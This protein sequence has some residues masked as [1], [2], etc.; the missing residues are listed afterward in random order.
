MARIIIILIAI[1]AGLAA[2]WMALQATW[3]PEP[4]A[5]TVRVEVPSVD[6]LVP[7]HNLIRGAKLSPDFVAWSS[8]PEDRVNSG[9]ILRAQEPD[10]IKDLGGR[11]LRS[12]VYTGE[13]LRREHLANGEG[14]FLSLILQ[15][16]TRAVG[17][18]IGDEKTAGGFVLPNDR[19]DVMH[20]VIRDMDGD[21]SATGATR[22]ILTNVRVL[23]IG[24][25][26]FGRES[27]QGKD[28]NLAIP[29]A[30]FEDD[31]TLTGKTAT[32]EV[33]TAQAEV[34]LSAAASGQL[35]LALRAAED[36]GLSGLGDLT[37]IEGLDG[38]KNAALTPKFVAAPSTIF[39]APGQTTEREVL[40]I[41]SGRERIIVTK[42][43]KPDQ[44]DGL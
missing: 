16:G 31:T 41:G 29:S 3:R 38:E 17:V 19:V 15:P 32:L 20:T 2:G 35:S 40:I 4:D 11:I 24:Q 13:P 7:Q 12:N 26:S 6:V 30:S 18:K 14:G 36:F 33:T 8:W 39:E 22:T 43:F 5:V 42:T 37:T 25:T 10:A 44:Q 28:D 1:S 27:L 9:M 34:L 21:G 23:A